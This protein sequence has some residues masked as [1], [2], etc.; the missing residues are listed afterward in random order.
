MLIF[1]Y[2]IKSEMSENP[3]AMRIKSSVFLTAFNY[4]K[5]EFIPHL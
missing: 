2:K 4:P 3:T 5:K 1:I